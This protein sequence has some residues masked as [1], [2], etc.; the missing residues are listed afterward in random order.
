[1]KKKFL[2]LIFIIMVCIIAYFI[3]SQPL[4]NAIESREQ[5]L[6]NEISKGDNWKISKEVEIEGY[7]ISGAY[8]ADNKS[9]LAIFKPVSNNKYKLVK[10]RNCNSNEIIISRAIINNN[11]YDLIWFN[12][13]KTQYA[14]IIYTIDGQIQDTLKYDTIDMDI[15]CNKNPE[16]EYTMNVRYYDDKGNKYE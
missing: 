7:I 14:E 9:T 3:W 12:G 15:I 1:M 11:N 16:K 4:G 8:S 13:A 5:I 10:S 6:N 2:L